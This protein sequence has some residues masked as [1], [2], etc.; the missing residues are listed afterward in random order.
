M[1]VISR[2]REQAA[3]TEPQVDTGDIG[4]VDAADLAALEDLYVRHTPDVDRSDGYRP[5]LAAAAR[6]H[7]QLAR[8][9]SPGQELIRVRPGAKEAAAESGRSGPGSVVEIIT[10]DMPYL[11][12]SVLASVRRAGTDVRRVVHPIV[13]VRRAP[14]GE[15]RDV[16]SDAD[17]AGP[18]T[19]SARRVVDPPRPRRRGPGRSRHRPGRRARRRP[20]GRPRRAGDG[21]P[22]HRRR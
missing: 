9:R 12:E 15:L 3:A 2:T 16:L 18:A 5:A 19:G 8:H 22:G 13:V 7:L 21:P 20:G 6:S 1:H 14:D 17:P 10:D 4:S 11:V